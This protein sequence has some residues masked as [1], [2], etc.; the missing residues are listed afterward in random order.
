MHC[1][2]ADNARCFGGPDER[3]DVLLVVGVVSAQCFAI[4]RPHWQWQGGAGLRRR[5]Q[6]AAG[7]LKEAHP[8]MNW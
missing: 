8:A 4:E 5:P 3:G 1:S 7:H 2:A 6:L